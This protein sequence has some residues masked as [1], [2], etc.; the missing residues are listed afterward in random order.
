MIWT[1]VAS[2]VSKKLYHCTTGFDNSVSQNNIQIQCSTARSKKLIIEEYFCR[3]NYTF[4][5]WQRMVF[6][7]GNFFWMI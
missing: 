3:S 2:V 6:Q 4:L 7:E 5:F 1:A